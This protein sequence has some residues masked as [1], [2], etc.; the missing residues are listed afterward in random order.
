MQRPLEAELSQGNTTIQLQC[1]QS[2]L[3]KKKTTTAER[4]FQT[5]PSRHTL[6]NSGELREGNFFEI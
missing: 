5:A 3:K 4:L 1:F 6:K 2:M